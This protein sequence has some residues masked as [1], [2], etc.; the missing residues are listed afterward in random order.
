VS[1]ARMLSRDI[2]RGR[3]TVRNHGGEGGANLIRLRRRKVWRRPPFPRTAWR[4]QIVFCWRRRRARLQLP[5]PCG[6]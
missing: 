1:M 3:M 6:E 4:E 5:A 2:T